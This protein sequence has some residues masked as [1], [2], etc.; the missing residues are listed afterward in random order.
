MEHLLTLGDNSGAL[1]TIAGL[2]EWDIPGIHCLNHKLELAI[3]K[4]YQGEQ[5]F[6]IIKEMLDTL[7]QLFRNSGKTWT[8]YQTIATSLGLPALRFAKLVELGFKLTY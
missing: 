7:F 2:V 4:T 1:T 6:A 3:K 5:D 8:L